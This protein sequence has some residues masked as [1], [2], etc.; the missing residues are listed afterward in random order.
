MQKKATDHRRGGARTASLSGLALGNWRL[1]LPFESSR[2]RF[3]RVD[4][5]AARARTSCRWPLTVSTDSRVSCP[6]RRSLCSVIE[7]LGALA[8]SALVHVPSAG[9]DWQIK[10]SL[11]VGAA[12][13][14]VPMVRL[15]P[16]PAP[17]SADVLTERRYEMLRRR[18]ISSPY[19]GFPRCAR[20]RFG[21]MSAHDIWGT[22]LSEY[23]RSAKDCV[24]VIHRSRRGKVPRHSAC[25]RNWC[26]LASP[27]MHSKVQWLRRQSGTSKL[28]HMA[29]E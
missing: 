28:L 20:H 9:A 25:P 2:A 12:G 15:G 27:R 8:P 5:H 17:T 3:R 22:S 21:S 14:I 18:G 4:A 10:Y 19:A 6:A 11:H 7:A 16:W 29:Q 23:V 26:V 24:V 13:V 1:L